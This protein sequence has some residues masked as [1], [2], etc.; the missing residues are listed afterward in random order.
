MSGDAVSDLVLAAVC[1]FLFFSNLRPR[2]GIA[3][4]CATVGLTAALGVLRYLGVAPAAGPHQFLVLVTKC[5][6]LP[7]LADAVTWPDGEPARTRRGAGLFLFMGTMVAVILVV[8]MSVKLWSKLAPGLAV[9]CLLVATI[10]ARRARPIGGAV[11][12][13]A[14]FAATAAGAALTPLSPDEVLHYGMAGALLLLAGGAMRG[15]SSRPV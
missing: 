3:L 10:R 14:T 13:A 12:L 11:L 2:P 4:A 8:G 9:L 6:G 15:P 1:A 7:L 5:A